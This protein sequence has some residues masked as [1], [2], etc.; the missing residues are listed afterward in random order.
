MGVAMVVVVVVGVNVTSPADLLAFG[1]KPADEAERT[2]DK[3][4]YF[5]WRRGCWWR[6]SPPKWRPFHATELADLCGRPPGLS[7]WLLSL[8]RLARLGWAGRPKR[9][10]ELRDNKNWPDFNFLDLSEI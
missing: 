3:N 7:S 8:V 9:R 1:A 10:A 5:T 2:S 4:K 6:R